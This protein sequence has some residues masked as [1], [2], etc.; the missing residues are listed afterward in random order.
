MPRG[1]KKGEN[2]FGEHQNEKT[3]LRLDLIKRVLGNVK[4]WKMSFP[5]IWQLSKYVSNEVNKILKDEYPLI[6]AK[7]KGKITAP[8]I[9]TKNESYKRELEKH[10]LGQSLENKYSE[11]VAKI[12]E[13]ELEIDELKDEVQRLNKY[14]KSSNIT[15]NIKSIPE[16]PLTNLDSQAQILA[17]DACHKIILAM[18]E[19]SDGVLVINNSQIEDPSE[20]TDNVV[21]SKAQLEQ[22]GLLESYLFKGFAD[23]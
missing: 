6:F 21:V 14:I 1:A 10:L 23:E 9:S 8:T 12:F 4:E 15:G 18:I 22:S 20:T 19:A 13:L 7:P 5:N 11:Q 16:K 17:L 2:R 3:D